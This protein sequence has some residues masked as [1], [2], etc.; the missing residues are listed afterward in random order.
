[1]EPKFYYC[2]HC[3]KVI[4][5]LDPQDTDTICCGSVMDLLTPGTEDASTEKHVPYVQ[6]SNHMV[7]VKVGTEE[8]PSLPEHYIKFIVLETDK[9]NYIRYLSPGCRPQATFHI[10]ESEKIIAVYEYCNLHKLWK[11]VL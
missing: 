2:R 10:C 1:M 6:I 7:Y 5:V 11:T 4:L 8:H 9:G 3:K